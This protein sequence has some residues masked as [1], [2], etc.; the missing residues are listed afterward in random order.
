MIDVGEAAQRLGVSETRVRAML[1][2]GI[3]EGRKIGRSWAI[4]EQSIAKRLHE[5][6]HPGRPSKHQEP[7]SLEAPDVDAAHRIYDEA[8]RVLV[9][10]YDSEFLRLARTSEERAFWVAVADFFLQQKQRELVEQ[11]VY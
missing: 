4:S 8:A 11:G 5:N 2:K 3:L 1:K 9:G 10:C 6:V 7:F